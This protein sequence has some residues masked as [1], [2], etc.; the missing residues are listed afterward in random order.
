MKYD[1][2]LQ[3]V[4]NKKLQVIK[5][6][7]ENTGLGLHEAQRMVDGT[8]T[9]LLQGVTQEEARTAVLQLQNLGA[10]VTVQEQSAMP[11][12]GAVADNNDGFGDNTGLCNVVLVDAGRMKINVIKELRE[13]TNLGLKETKDMVDSA[14][15]VLFQGV[16]PEV[17]EQIRL[18][19][20]KVGATVNVNC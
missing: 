18:A 14:P 11:A 16:N 6:I 20:T 7:R 10:V 13:I 1:V 12:S 4:G 15:T 3:D 17:A 2:I 19:L 8:P 5:L 9:L